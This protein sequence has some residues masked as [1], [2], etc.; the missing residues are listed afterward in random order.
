MTAPHP[1]ATCQPSC[2]PERNG[3]PR[4]VYRAAPGNRAV[5][6]RR[7]TTV[8]PRVSLAV[9]LGSRTNCESALRHPSTVVVHV[10]LVPS[11]ETRHESTNRAGRLW[12][13]PGYL[14]LKQER[15]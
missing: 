8:A 9:R 10:A 2:C 6:G 4:I 11:R 1:T 5:A 7:P 14:S 15:G 3:E 13:W 12:A